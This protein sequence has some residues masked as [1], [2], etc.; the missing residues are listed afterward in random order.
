MLG[1]DIIVIFSCAE[2]VVIEKHKVDAT[3]FF[4]ELPKVQ[5]NVA[6]DAVWS[7][8]V[9]EQSVDLNAPETEVSLPL[10]GAKRVREI[11]VKNRSIFCEDSRQLVPLWSNTYN[12]YCCNEFHPPWP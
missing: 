9:R 3:A 6:C 12:T 5:K 10:E 8:K 2:L 11:Q 1:D 4:T 7:A